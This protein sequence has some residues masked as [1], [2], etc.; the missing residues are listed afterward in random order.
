MATRSV[1]INPKPAPPPAPAPTPPP[2]PGWGPPPGGG[3]GGAPGPAGN[4]GNKLPRDRNET[5]LESDLAKALRERIAAE[6]ERAGAVDQLTAPLGKLAGLTGDLA[7]AIVKASG[8]MGGK[9]KNDWRKDG[10]GAGSLGGLG[11]K[12]GVGGLLGKAG[13]WV[14][15]AGAAKDLLQGIGD[16]IA[17]VLNG[18]KHAVEGAG[19]TAP[20]LAPNDGL[21]A[22]TT[23]VDTAADVMGNIPVVGSAMAAGMKLATGS[24][25]VF[26]GVI[27]S[28]GAR[29]R[30]L[31]TLNPVL[32]QTVAEVDVQKFFADLAE[33]NRNE[34]E[35]RDLIVAQAKL[36]RQWQTAITDL[37]KELL[38][39][40]T[41]MARLVGLIAKMLPKIIESLA[42]SN[43]M[44]KFLKNIADVLDAQLDAL[45][46]IDANT[47]PA[48]DID[49]DGLNAIFQMANQGVNV[50]QQPAP[51]VRNAFPPILGG[52]LK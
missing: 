41:R 23:A 44:F 24:L 9:D 2:N 12:G 29:G 14:A 39:W 28:L 46:Q 10:G 45:D 33:A 4:P 43:P 49:A 15:V 36:D 11:G 38:P 3:K 31:S 34:A 32:A 30:E 21:G 35:Y 26:K 42:E 50:P 22:L 52:L 13:P 5:T 27:D 25:N 20:T 47:K 1:P 48:V 17:D 6:R 8:A 16:S 40:A 19:Q 18:V 7:V 37:K 51:V